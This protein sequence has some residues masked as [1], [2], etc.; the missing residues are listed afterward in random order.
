MTILD[1]LLFTAIGYVSGSVLWSRYIPLLFAGTDIVKISRDHNPGTSNVMKH[2]GVFLGMICLVLDL[3]K[4]FVP[5]FFAL[6]A[7]D[8]WNNLFAFIMAAPVVGHAYSCFNGFKGGKAIATTFGVL[9]ALYPKYQLILILC[10]VYILT[11]LD[12][13]IQPNEKKTVLTFASLLFF[14][15]VYELFLGLPL[16]MLIGMVIIDI[17]VI[18]KNRDHIVYGNKKEELADEDTGSDRHAE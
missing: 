12:H 11:A 18:H 4:G 6:K 7:V 13:R 8:E 9:I 2:C 3:A 16:S 5:V 17:V 14:T 15:L 1:F 10:S